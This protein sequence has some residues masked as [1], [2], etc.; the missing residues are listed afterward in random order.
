M[1]ANPSIIFDNSTLTN[2]KQWCW[3]VLGG[4]SYTTP[5]TYAI[6][7]FIQNAGFVQTNDSGQVNW[8]T[9]T[10]T[11]TASQASGSTATFT[12]SSL[13]G[14][15]GALRVGM[16]VN[17]ITGLTGN[18]GLNQA[19]GPLAGFGSVITAVTGTTFSI[20]YSGSTLTSQPESGTLNIA[21]LSLNPTSTDVLVPNNS[22]YNGV[23]S[24]AYTTTYRGYWSGVTTYAIGDVVS[25]N[26]GTSVNTY[27]SLINS[28]T[29]NA[30]PNSSSNA[31]WK[32]YN[33]EVWGFGNGDGL[34][35]SSPWY[36]KLEYG[37]I[38]TN[39]PAIGFTIGTATTG[40]G[41]LTT[42]GNNS[43][44]EIV[45]YSSAT[46]NS[47]NAY[48]CDFYADSSNN[49]K[50]AVIMWRTGSSSQNMFLGFERSKSNTGA[51]TGLY[52]TYLKGQNPNA[53]WTQCSVQATGTPWSS[54]QRS[55]SYA[56]SLNAA[57]SLSTGQFGTNIATWPVFPYLGY[58]GNPLTIV[59]GMH[60]T[61][62]IEG[63]TYS[64]T[65]YGGSHTYLIT[66]VANWATYFANGS[67]TAFA[68]R[69]E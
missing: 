20:P 58:V 5:G 1:H 13:S 52:V 64:T 35:G 2:Y 31:D 9:I 17:T 67:G 10:A 14:G 12:Y 33:Y 23:G 51:E 66:K 28:N 62:A 30:P 63:Q 42:S 6:S 25:Y 47:S 45:G 60:T 40:T 29:N 37:N 22:T 18:P 56:I 19:S 46:A 4:G 55:T 50:F 54:S 8:N 34:Q 61:D 43:Y 65:V 48:E 27:V 53:A 15:N 57:V 7:S 39:C 16:I 3:G 36:F 11:I 49:D 32:V 41:A 38:G 69:Y 59:Q 44:R 21:A 68:M 24:A 26:A